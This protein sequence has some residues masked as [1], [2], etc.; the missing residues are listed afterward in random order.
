MKLNALPE[1]LLNFEYGT[2]VLYLIGDNIPENIGSSN[3][4]YTLT[5]SARDKT[6][7]RLTM[8]SSQLILQ[9]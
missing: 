7:Y 3:I 4:V 8:L 2:D 5:R 9:S 1:T 6:E